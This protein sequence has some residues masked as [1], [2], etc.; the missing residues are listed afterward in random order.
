MQKVKPLKVKNCS[1]VFHNI[2]FKK[3]KTKLGLIFAP[4]ITILFLTRQKSLADLQVPLVADHKTAQI[5][6]S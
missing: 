4:N 6:Y 1:T 2:K 5:Q 3:K